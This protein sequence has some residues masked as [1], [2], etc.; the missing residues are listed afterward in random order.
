MTYCIEK[1]AFVMSGISSFWC[2]VSFCGGIWNISIKIIYKLK[3]D[4]IK[5]QTHSSYRG[6]YT[7]NFKGLFHVKRSLHVVQACIDF[8]PEVSVNSC[9]CFCNVQNV[10]FY[11]ICREPFFRSSGCFFYSKHKQEGKYILLRYHPFTKLVF[12]AASIVLQSATCDEEIIVLWPWQSQKV[13][14]HLFSILQ[15][16]RGGRPK[17]RP[18][19]WI[20]N[21]FRES[22]IFIFVDNY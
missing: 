15:A 14:I 19:S 21:I 22:S 12:Y 4:I 10:F 3:S 20:F 6:Q 7:R 11:P 2:L 13:P 5:T 9:S 1:S 16:K 18:N 17:V 8:S